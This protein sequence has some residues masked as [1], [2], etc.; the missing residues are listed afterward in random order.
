MSVTLSPDQL[1]ETDHE[2]L[3]ELRDGRVTP[4]YLSERLEISRPYAS[5]RLKRLYE[6]EHIDRIASGLYEL[7]DDPE[8]GSE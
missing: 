5:E 6:H 3:R 7:T 1:N 8:G 4:G 2:I